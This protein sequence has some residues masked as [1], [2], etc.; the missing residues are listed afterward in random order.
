MSANRGLLFVLALTPGILPWASLLARLS[1]REIVYLRRDR[2]L[3]GEAGAK[4]IRRAGARAL[5]FEDCHDPERGYYYGDTP[6]IATAVADRLTATACF[7]RTLAL[8]GDIPDHG[9]KLDIV[10]RSYVD[11]D[12]FDLTHVLAWYTGQREPGPAWVLAP[13]GGIR[14]RYLAASGVA[15]RPCPGS[16]LLGL[17]GIAGALLSP[18]RALLPSRRGSAQAAPAGPPPELPGLIRNPADFPASVLYFPHQTVSYGRLFFKDQFYSPD[19]DSPY[20]AARILHVETAPLAA[21]HV[22]PDLAAF[23]RERDIHHAVLPMP[24]GGRRL[25]IGAIALVEVLRRAGLSALAGSTA[26]AAFLVQ[27][28]AR[29]RFRLFDEALGAFPAARVALIGYEILAPKLLYLALDARGIRT[30]ASQERFHAPI[31]FDNWNF[32]LDTYFTGSRTISG[33]VNASRFKHAAHAVAVGQVRTD[34]LAEFR[35][36]LRRSEVVPE[37]RG[38]DRMAVVFDPPGVTDPDAARLMYVANTRSNIAFFRDIANLAERFPRT[39]FVIR[40]KDTRWMETEPYRDTVA[41]IDARPNLLVSRDYQSAA[42]QYRIAAL[43]DLVIAKYTSIGDECMGLG[44]PVLYHD[45]TPVLPT[46]ASS[47]WD[48]GGI[49][50][51]VHDF[52][53]LVERTRAALDRGHYLEPGQVERLSVLV[54]DGIADGKV[55]QRIR[56]YLD[57][58]L[59]ET[60]ASPAAAP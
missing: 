12:C 60:K 5:S 24:T 13:M 16:S 15:V 2:R 38:Y 46:G 34:L 11:Q 58:M 8:Y 18:L 10:L 53:T 20:H 37:S 22:T 32:I 59:T 56:S 39:L 49:P 1:N 27:C 19:P 28:R 42:M 51:F 57:G 54:N 35:A 33:I 45:Y 44:I 21:R 29:W 47:V 41:M 26:I 3:D 23:H 43:A 25:R 14:R 36:N 9:K 55:R 6:G 30:A 52:G 7:R 40:S 17:L 31:F 48:Y 4:R 50:V